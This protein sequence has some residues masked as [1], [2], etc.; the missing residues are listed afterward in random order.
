VNLKINENSKK[1]QFKKK[2]IVAKAPPVLNTRPAIYPG[3]P[4]LEATWQKK[5]VATPLFIYK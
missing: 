2:L 4:F 3:P 5:G 1:M